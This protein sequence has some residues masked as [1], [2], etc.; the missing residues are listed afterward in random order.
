M[1]FHKNN[2]YVK[3]LL[4]SFTIHENLNL[5]ILKLKM[6]IPFEPEVQFVNFLNIGVSNKKTSKQNYY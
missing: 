4:S 6:L 2:Y 5:I 3:Y 1:K